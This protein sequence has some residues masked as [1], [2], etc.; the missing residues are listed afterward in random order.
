MAYPASV[1][2]ELPA[3]HPEHPGTLADP[4]HAAWCDYR[5]AVVTAVQAARLSLAEL[6]ANPGD[7]RNADLAESHVALMEA[8]LGLGRRRMIDE[9]ILKDAEQR[10][11]AQG[12]ADCKA[13]RYNL[14]VVGGRG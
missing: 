6:A 4:A 14:S 10:A 11:Y 1:P 5:R 13:A 12:V 7:P 9:Q 3:G 8:L 2:A